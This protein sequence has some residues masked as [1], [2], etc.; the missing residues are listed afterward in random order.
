MSN[1]RKKAIAVVLALV[2]AFVGA[3]FGFQYMTDAKQIDGKGEATV[4]D[5]AEL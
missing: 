3:R 2:I 1:G 5:I 4:Y